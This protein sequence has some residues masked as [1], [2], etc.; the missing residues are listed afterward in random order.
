MKQSRRF[1]AVLKL[2]QPGVEYSLEDAVAL[3]KKK[4]G[5]REV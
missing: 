2:V 4:N 3:L 1:E 5:D